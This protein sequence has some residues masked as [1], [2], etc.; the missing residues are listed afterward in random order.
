MH[1]GT[2]EVYLLLDNKALLV[3]VLGYAIPMDKHPLVSHLHY[4]CANISHESL[5]HGTAVSPNV[6]CL[7]RA[8]V[9]PFYN[10]LWQRLEPGPQWTSNRLGE[11]SGWRHPRMDVFPWTINPL[12]KMCG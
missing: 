9:E 4:L 1:G 8:T 11:E 12:A 5:L 3:C 2:A 6:L 10:E 7:S